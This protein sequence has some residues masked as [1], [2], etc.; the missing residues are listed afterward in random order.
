MRQ[1]A[2][3]LCRIYFFTIN[4]SKN[5]G[6]VESKNSIALFFY[7]EMRKESGSVARKYKRLSYEDRK[8]IEARHNRKRRAIVITTPVWILPYK[9][10]RGRNGGKC[11]KTDCD[12]CQFPPC[13]KGEAEND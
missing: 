9:M 10:L 8:E 2:L 1:E 5:K 6:A 3:N 4:N 12:S 11:E 13:E 7:P